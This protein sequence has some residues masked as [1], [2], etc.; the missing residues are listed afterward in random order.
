MYKKHMSAIEAGAYVFL[1]FSVPLE[2]VGLVCPVRGIH[3]N[4]SYNQS[5]YILRSTKYWYI[6]KLAV[7]LG[8][9]RHT[10]LFRVCCVKIRAFLEAARVY[11]GQNCCA[12]LLHYPVCMTSTCTVRGLRLSHSPGCMPVVDSCCTPSPAYR[13][14]QAIQCLAQRMYKSIVSAPVFYRER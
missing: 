3:Q 5:V 2:N 7:A 11:G 14:R 1:I 10:E 8:S 4:W 13:S 9:N 6:T 12:F